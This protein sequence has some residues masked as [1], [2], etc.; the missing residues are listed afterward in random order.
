MAKTNAERQ[1]EYRERKRRE[2]EAEGLPERDVNEAPSGPAV[3]DVSPSDDAE[4]SIEQ[5]LVLPV[6]SELTSEEEQLLR[7]HFGY[8]ASERRSRDERAATAETMRKG[9]P[10]YSQ[11]PSVTAAVQE[12]KDQDERLAVRAQD[13]RDSIKA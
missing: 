8:T 9:L 6:G 11:H 10:D 13:Y 1:A 12:L 2:L 4:R 3:V 7:E 5:L